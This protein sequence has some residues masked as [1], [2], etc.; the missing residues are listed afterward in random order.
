MMKTVLMAAAAVLM[1]GTGVASARSYYY[2]FGNA[3]SIQSG[4]NGL[5]NMI[6][7]GG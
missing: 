1:L 4:S 5:G 6:N 2:D 3:S 7:Q